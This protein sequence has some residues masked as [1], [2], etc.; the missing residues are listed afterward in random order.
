MHISDLNGYYDNRLA[1]LQQI[2]S[3]SH[4]EDYR[5]TLV[6]FEERFCFKLSAAVNFMYMTVVLV[7]DVVKKNQDKLAEYRNMAEENKESYDFFN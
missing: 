3:Y 4:L 7:Y 2:I 5:L 1:H 6:R